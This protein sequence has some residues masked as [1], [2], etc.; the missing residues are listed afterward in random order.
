MDGVNPAPTPSTAAAHII[1]R[2]SVL[3][4]ILMAKK[5]TE[6]ENRL[7]RYL[8]QIKELLTKKGAGEFDVSLRESAE[9]GEVEIDEDF[10]AFGW[11][12]LDGGGVRGKEFCGE[13][14]AQRGA[15]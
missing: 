5:N 1:R 8:T 13:L 2:G 7:E 3:K 4:L 6:T 10:G 11:R 12:D 9:G 15:G 14:E